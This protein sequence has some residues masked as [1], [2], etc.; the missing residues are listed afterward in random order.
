MSIVTGILTGG[1]NA[2]QTTSEEANAWATDFISEGIVG[3][4][5]STNG[6]AP[7]TGS[8]SINAQGTPDMT[9]AV[10]SGTA[11]VTGTPS[12]QASQTF[13]VKNSA[14][15]NVTIS[16]NSSG[17]TK[18]DWV[19]IKLDATKLNTPNTAGDDVAT[20]V[21]SRSSS[22]SSDDGTPPTYG[23]P[24]A[25][26]TVANGAVSITNSNIRDLRTQ[27]TISST[28]AG[29][30]NDWY[31]TSLSP[32]TVTAL[33]N[34]SYS[35]VFNSTDL[36]SYISNGMRL[37]LPRTVT[38]PTQCASLNGTNQ[39]F[40]RTSAG[41]AAMTFTDDFV[42]SAW[43]KLSS[44]SASSQLI[45]SRYNGTSG[46]DLSVTAAGQIQ[47]AGRNAA[48]G[49]YRL[50]ASYQSIPLNKWV[51]VS[52]QLDMSTYTATTTTCYV[53]IDGKDV[54]ATLGQ[55]GTNPTTLIQAGNLEIG[56]W[57]GGLLPFSGKIAQ[58]AIYSAKVTQATILASMNQ[59]LTGSETSLVCGYTFNGVVTDVSS[60]G[61]TLTAQNSAAA[62]TV[63]SPMNATEYA[64]VM[65]NSF[66][67]NTTLT[68]QVPEG[69]SLPTSGGIGTVSY[70]TQ[71][72]PYGFPV[73]NEKL[74]AEVLLVANSTVT[75]TGAATDIPGLTHT[76]T[77]PTTRAYKITAYFS[78]IS[79]ATGAPPAIT[80]NLTDGSNNILTGLQL[81][82]GGANYQ[83]TT[84]LNSESM[85]LA[86]GSTTLKMRGTAASTFS[87][88]SAAGNKTYLRIEEA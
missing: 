28:T 6:I 33:G 85:V 50:I 70:S 80:L 88:N 2:H 14:S 36:T 57:N 62:T 13:R 58:V 71:K 11:Y 23:Y 4:V 7:T 47:L 42:V 82:S 26:V 12:S 86:A 53:M 10:G 67:T 19:Y 65:A 83:N 74:V 56:S 64:I 8:F 40:N 51:H 44:Y 39:Y 18:Y 15:S 54:P 9:I 16:A 31:S 21:T 73:Y 79:M 77:V 66:S 68:V 25:V 17:S 45:A 48:T 55:G 78:N 24:L 43:V 27:S 46:W 49:N 75:S 20:L 41:L 59:T 22:A 37:K 38:P 35:L 5:G 72:T 63:D 52:A 1:A 32:N 87:L 69:Y 81:Q 76:F 34:R 61:Y 29:T 30:S 3:S 60:N 84:T